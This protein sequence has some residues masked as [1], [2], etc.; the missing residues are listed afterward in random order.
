MTATRIGCYCSIADHVRTCFGSH[1]T[2]VA[3]STFPAFY[4]DTA[5]GLG[6]TYSTTSQQEAGVY[7]KAAEDFIVDIGND[8]WIG[9]HVLIMDGVRIG[10]GAIVAAG[11]VVT[12]DVPPY[13]I[14]GGVPAKVLK[15]RFTPKQ[16]EFLLQFKWWNRDPQWIEAHWKDFQNIKQ[17]MEKHNNY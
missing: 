8:V 10:D 14:V 4:Y 11:A 6:Y 7:K 1:P 9:S 5:S 17:F 12:K 16:I 13:A 3:V 2:S 15:Y